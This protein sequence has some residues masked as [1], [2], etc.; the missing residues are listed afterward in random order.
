MYLKLRGRGF[1]RAFFKYHVSQR[2]E[3]QYLAKTPHPRM[4]FTDIG[5]HA[6]RYTL[7]VA[8]AVVIRFSARESA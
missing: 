4:M 8:E 7:L 2:G 6:G 3:M 5:A 1:D